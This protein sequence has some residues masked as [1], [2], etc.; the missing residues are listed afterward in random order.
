MTNVIP[1]RV[2]PRLSYMAKS[3]G[4]WCWLSWSPISFR[5]EENISYMED[6]V[7]AVGL[8]FT[9]ERILYVTILEKHWQIELYDEEHPS[10][11]G[12]NPLFCNKLRMT[13]SWQFKVGY[14]CCLSLL[15]MDRLDGKKVVRYRYDCQS[16]ID[17]K[18]ATGL[19]CIRTPIHQSHTVDTHKI[20]GVR[21]THQQQCLVIKKEAKL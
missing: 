19:L 13:I 7:N 18:I 11:T 12:V 17:H 16:Q 8:Q 10:P 21:F 1:L 5:G 9:Y 20:F 3:L 4:R 2:V 15:T 14:Y 6:R